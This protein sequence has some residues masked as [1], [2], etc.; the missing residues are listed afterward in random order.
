MEINCSF[1][2]GQYTGTLTIDGKEY[3]VYLSRMETHYAD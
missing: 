2:S 3:K 1:E